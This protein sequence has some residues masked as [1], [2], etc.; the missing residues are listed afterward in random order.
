MKKGYLI[1]DLDGTIA[2][3]GERNIFF[4]TN[5]RNYRAAE[6]GVIHD[7]IIEPIHTLVTEM[8]NAGYDIIVMSAREESCKAITKKW[9]EL[10]GIPFKDIYM[11]KVDDFRKDFIVKREMLREIIEKEGQPLFAL[12]DRSDV[13]EMFAEEGVFSLR[14]NNVRKLA[15]I[16]ENSQDLK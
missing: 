5:P 8:N 10:R 13:V 14:V 15:K 16:D 3:S 12:E 1:L 2:V 6:A 9:L 7:E 4:T 11:K